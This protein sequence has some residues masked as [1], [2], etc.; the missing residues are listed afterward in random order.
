VLTA[1]SKAAVLGIFL[2]GAATGSPVKAG[3]TIEVPLVTVQ[4]TSW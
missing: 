4:R 2:A 1:M 3:R